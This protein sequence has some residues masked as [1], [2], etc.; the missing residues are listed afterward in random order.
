MLASLQCLYKETKH[1][2]T[3][4]PILVLGALWFYKV[5]K[6]ANV[7]KLFSFQSLGP[8]C[9]TVGASLGLRQWKAT[10]CFLMGIQIKVRDCL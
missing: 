1:K 7:M 10:L 3:D 9:H 4:K 6:Y 2:N 8:F 5:G